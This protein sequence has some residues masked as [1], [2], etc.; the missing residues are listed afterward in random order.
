MVMEWIKNIGCPGL[1]LC[2]LT[3]NSG[4]VS[5]A[6]MLRSHVNIFVRP[7]LIFPFNHTSLI[8]LQQ[9]SHPNVIKYL[10]SW[11][12]CGELVIV[13]EL[14][15]AGDISRMLHYFR[16]QRRLLPECSVWKYF[17]QICAGLTHMHT[18][19]VMHRGMCNG[20]DPGALP[21]DLT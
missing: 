4:P 17:V 7:S 8:F 5:T 21:Q 13:L 10:G 2:H 18:K 20:Q 11:V 19:R 6:K 15:N 3:Q 12:Q 9:L 14:A 1:N 16:R